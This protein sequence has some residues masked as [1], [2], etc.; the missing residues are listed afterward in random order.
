VNMRVYGSE[1]M[2][3]DRHTGHV[4]RGNGRNGLNKLMRMM[5]GLGLVPLAACAPQG[6][7]QQNLAD[8]EAAV[9]SI[10]CE[11]VT[12]A[13]YLPVELQAGLTREQATAITQYM[14]AS[15]RAKRLESGGIRLKTGGCA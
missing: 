1:R 4:Q 11:L 14:V 6:T 8:Y 3:A 12:E 5:W 13:D 7:T 2:S 9:A 10:G 15:G